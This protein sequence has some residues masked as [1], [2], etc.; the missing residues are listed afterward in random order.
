MTKRWLSTVAATMCVA[1]VYALSIPGAHAQQLRPVAVFRAG[2]TIAGRNSDP[3]SQRFLAPFQ[4]AIH[5]LARDEQYGEYAWVI[6]TANGQ[7]LIAFCSQVQQD[8]QTGGLVFAGEVDPTLPMFYGG[9][10]VGRVIQYQ[11]QLWAGMMVQSPQGAVEFWQ[12][13]VPLQS[14]PGTPGGYTPGIP[15]GPGTSGG[16]VPGGFGGPGGLPPF[17][18]GDGGY[19]DGWDDG[20]DDHYP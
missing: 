11:G 16:Y 13:L 9:Q 6:F 19:D 1:G 7:S 15:G 4:G 12:T 18:G 5:V 14:D 3:A 17:P 8:P 20:Y 2:Q 10:I